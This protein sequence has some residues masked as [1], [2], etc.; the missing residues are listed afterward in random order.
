MSCKRNVPKQTSETYEIQIIKYPKIA[1]S[2]MFIYIE[3]NA[4]DVNT[5]QYY[6][7]TL[8]DWIFIQYSLKN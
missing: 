1:Y 3:I 8:K 7:K 4:L 2:Y 5:I 6:V